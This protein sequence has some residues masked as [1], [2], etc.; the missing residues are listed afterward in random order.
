EPKSGRPREEWETEEDPRRMQLF[1]RL[2]KRSDRKLRLFGCACCRRVWHLLVDA[3]S[4]DAL[5]VAERYAEGRADERA[6]SRAP[7][8]ARRAAQSLRG[9]P[10]LGDAA[11]GVLGVIAPPA[12][13]TLYVRGEPVGARLYQADLLRELFGPLPFTC[14][15]ADPSWLTWNDGAVARL[16]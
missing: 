6:R 14:V 13:L 11:E 2:V 4:R 12:D 1:L 10:E 5:E 15:E 16:A 3:R 9:H 7:G 8:G